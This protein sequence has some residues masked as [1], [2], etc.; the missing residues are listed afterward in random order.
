MGL[1]VQL[2]VFGHRKCP[3]Y[4]IYLVF[5]VGAFYLYAS[6]GVVGTIY[7]Y[8]FLP[9]TRGRSLE[10]MESLFSGP[11]LVRKKQSYQSQSD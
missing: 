8:L 1:Q 3:A 6:F 2:W 9:E 4:I 5:V 11:W 10:E 7:F